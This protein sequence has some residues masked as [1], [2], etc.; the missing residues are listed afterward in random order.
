MMIDTLLWDFNGTV[1]DDL[2]AS[3]GAVNAMLTRRGLPLISKEWYTLHLIMPLDAFYE[4]VGLNMKKEKLAEVSEEFQQE[5]RKIP[6]PV[7]PEVREALAGFS[8][9]GFRQLLFSSLYHDTLMAQAQERQITSYFQGIEG[10]RDRSLGGKEKA[11]EAYLKAHSI[12][13]K[14]VLVIGDL[15]TDYEMARYIG[16]PCALIAKGHQHRSVL[17]KTGAYVLE[18]A[19][20][21]DALLEE[22]K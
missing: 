21:L 8:Q 16:A 22:L 6:R 3:V 18:D 9:K 17:E 10:L 12:D 7:F 14:G 2:G 1:M 15:T 5:C 20:F 13:P 4:S 19:S 11:V